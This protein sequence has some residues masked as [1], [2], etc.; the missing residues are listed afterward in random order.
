MASSNFTD[1]TT[2]DFVPGNRSLYPHGTNENGFNDMHYTDYGHN[3][4]NGTS[5]DY[6]TSYE[7]YLY[8]SYPFERPVYLYIWEILVIC[9][10]LVNI[11][12]I[13]ILLRKNMR[14][15]TNIILAAIAMSDSLTGLTTLPTYIMVYLSLEEP[16]NYDDTDFQDMYMYHTYGMSESAVTGNST[17]DYI[18][19][20]DGRDMY[21]LS[22]ALCRWFMISKLFISQS[23]HTMSIYLTLCL[24]IQRFIAVAS[25][26]S[27][28]ALTTQKALITCICIALLAPVFHIY[29]FFDEK[30][31]NGM[32][33]WSLEDEG[34]ESGCIYLWVM[35][36]MR[37]FIPCCVL[38]IF[39]ILFVY[40][41]RQ[42]E[43]NI[44]GMNSKKGQIA[45]R[46][47]E[48][49]RIAIV[50]TAIVIVFLISEIPYGFFM[51]Y[52]AIAKTDN[53][54]E[55]INLKRNREIHLAYE[56]LLVLSFQANFFIYVLFNR[57]FR[58][59]LKKMLLKPFRI[60]VSD[61]RRASTTSSNMSRSTLR[62][63]ELMS[64]KSPHSSDKMNHSISNSITDK[65]NVESTA[66]MNSVSADITQS[67][68]HDRDEVSALKATV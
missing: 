57:K 17:S 67:S 13:S 41:L 62:Q 18:H 48:N 45:R 39:T 58:K 30:A 23:F 6:Q 24:G 43:V 14:S 3:H 53:N 22:K 29:H 25:P 31:Q 15:A 64:M 60:V 8:M 27:A 56:I 59:Y 61:T 19:E 35:F 68:Q 46:V 34:C 38:S 37:Q 66:F 65:S 16:P 32:C 63:T 28:R 9:T 20:M 1:T 51:L 5:P 12:V 10:C 44:R 49:R 50:V 42:G 11:V 54:G 55:N 7:D 47:V 21:V 40:E 33:E 36:F 2:V 4:S 26:F 52:N